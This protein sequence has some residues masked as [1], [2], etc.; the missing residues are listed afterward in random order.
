MRVHMSAPAEGRAT[1]MFLH[2]QSR[3][4]ASELYLKPNPNPKP[5][6]VA[7]ESVHADGLTTRASL[8]WR[9]RSRGSEL[10]ARSPAAA[11]PPAAHAPADGCPESTNTVRARSARSAAPQ[12]LRWR[13]ALSCSLRAASTNASTCGRQR[14]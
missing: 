4:R 1:R 3:S 7:H 14:I 11:L 6:G 9:G 5:C 2:W 12:A 8:Y 10:A 13:R